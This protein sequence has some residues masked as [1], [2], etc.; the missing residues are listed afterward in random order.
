M[1]LE[2]W[3]G[4]RNYRRFTV[5]IA[6]PGVVSSNG[7]GLETG[8]KVILTT[9]GALPTGI[10]AD[11]YYYVIE[12]TYSDGS[13]DP[14]TFKFATTKANATAGTAIT[15]SGSQSGSHYYAPAA[16]GRMVPAVENDR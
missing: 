13:T 7:H 8:D 2:D 9:T 5:T 11:T 12:G 16:R 15:T 10:V 1:A 14:D 3:F 6:T 4:T